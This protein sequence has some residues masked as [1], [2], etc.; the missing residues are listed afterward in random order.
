MTTNTT[1]TLMSQLIDY[2]KPFKEENPNYNIMV[3]QGRGKHML[4]LIKLDEPKI[5]GKSSCRYM[6]EYR[7]LSINCE[8][9]DDQAYVCVWDNDV[10]Y[11]LRKEVKELLAEIKI[12]ETNIFNHFNL[13]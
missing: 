12:G 10:N 5:I 11:Y 9:P 1:D 8:K 7:E 4:I 6:L 13:F 2:T 3:A